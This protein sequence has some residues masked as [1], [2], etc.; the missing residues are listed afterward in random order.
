MKMQK[1]VTALALAL[2]LLLGVC[3][4]VGALAADIPVTGYV[5]PAGYS[6]NDFQRLAAFALQG[7]NLSALNWDL[8][9]VPPSMPGIS[10]TEIEG[11]MRADEISLNK[12]GDIALTGVMD[13]TDLSE[14]RS[15]SVSNNQLF[16]INLSGCSKLSSLVCDNNQLVKLVLPDVTTMSAFDCANNYLNTASG[17]ALAQAIQAITFI[18]P[19]STVQKTFMPAASSAVNQVSV[20]LNGLPDLELRYTT[21]GITPTINS[22]VVAASG[23]EALNLTASTM[24]QAAA[25]LPDGTLSEV[26]SRYFTVSTPTP[27]LPANNGVS[28]TQKISLS[29]PANTTYIYTTDG[30][31][32]SELNGIRFTGAKDITISKNTTLKLAALRQGCT[33][34]SVAS[35][36]YTVVLPATAAPVLPSNAGIGYEQRVFMS[37]PAS[38]TIYYTVDGSVPQTDGSG[39]TQTIL[40]NQSK[41]VTIDKQITIKAIAWKVGFDPSAVVSKAYLCKAKTPDLPTPLSNPGI[42]QDVLFKAPDDATLFYTLDGKTPTTSSESLAPGTRT[43][44]NITK[45]TTL[46][47]IA[48]R[49]G[50][51]NSDVATA[52]F[53]VTIPVS[54]LPKIPAG[55]TGVGSYNIVV[56]VPTG[57]KYYY[58]LDGKTPT[59]SSNYLNGGKQYTMSVTF[60]KTMK[61]FAVQNNYKP[62]AVVTSVYRVQTQTPTI[63]SAASG[64]G[65]VKV[66]LKAPLGFTW[67]YTTNDTPPSIKSAKVTPGTTKTITLTKTT[68][69]RVIAVKSGCEPS[70]AAVVTFTITTTTPKIPASKTA[71]GT[72]KVNLSPP[73]GTTWHY[74]LD[75][76]KPSTGTSAY[77]I[78]GKTKTLTIS[79]NIVLNVIAVKDNC[80]PSAVVASTFRVRTAAPKIPASK[81]G[82]SSYKVTITVPNN[83][84]WYITLDGSVPTTSKGTRLAGGTKRTLSIT[85][86]VMLR[87]IAVAPGCDASASVSANYLYKL[88]VPKASLAPGTY[89]GTKTIKLSTSVKGGTIYY[90]TNG[91]TPTSAATKYTKAIKITKNTTLKLIVAKPGFTIS[92]ASVYTYTIKK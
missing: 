18:S 63:P 2:A 33:I 5:T 14:L 21:N 13:L 30:T 54:P 82:Y 49:S 65:S 60:T 43:I 31:T 15:L 76:K 7:N 77:V 72:Y 35:G 9:A 88:P 29:A 83:V 81:T 27:S 59:T 25:V 73:T 84:T 67:Y 44:L 91:K 90:T 32:P 16:A 17:S 12:T 34:S 47:A 41:G 3:G 56:N 51:H 55:K 78:G 85:K 50:Y 42:T 36:L 62:S 20:T 28:A 23:I 11:I 74:T 86:N 89:K 75:G 68:K 45:K 52:V 79:R 87:V 57:Y 24:L 26:H 10:F 92:N 40:P 53:T 48:V 1:K 61:A 71:T 58:T 80:K 64:V 8:Q 38:T 22:A 37:A 70:N 39:T 66:N 69:L 46:K 4:P 6:E 19:A